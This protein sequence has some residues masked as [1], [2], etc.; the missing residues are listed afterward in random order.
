[1]R[2]KTKQI[3]FTK[4]DCIFLMTVAAASALDTAEEVGIPPDVIR[5]DAAEITAKLVMKL[6]K[7]GV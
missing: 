7:E 6:F 5:K 4:K 3:T 2:K 1:M